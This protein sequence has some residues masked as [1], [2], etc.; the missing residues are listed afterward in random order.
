MSDPRFRALR[1]APRA[2]F[3]R[4]ARVP[5]PP[6]PVAIASHSLGWLRPHAPS[7]AIPAPESRLRSWTIRGLA[8]SALAVTI[9]YLVWRATATLDPTA[10]V[11]SIL[12]LVLEIHAALGLALFTF[13]LWDIDTRP[14]VASVATAP[15][16][17][18]VLIPTYNE[19]P[20]ILLPTVAAAVAMRLPHETWVLDDGNRPEVERLAAELGARYVAR[21]TH[22]HAKAGNINHALGLVEADYVAILDADHVASPDLLAH[23]LGYFADPTVALVQTPQDFYNRAS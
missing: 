20:E 15:G 13:G 19:A 1:V 23:T 21:A 2:G 11:L 14:N 5:S 17:V 9:V 8:L 16:R 12:L 22:E 10:P 18:A 6:S 3:S 4:A 7:S